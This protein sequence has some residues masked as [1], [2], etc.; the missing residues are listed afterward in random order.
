[1]SHVL[2]VPEMPGPDVRRS[3][4]RRCQVIAGT[5]VDRSFAVILL[6]KRAESIDPIVRRVPGNE[7]NVPTQSNT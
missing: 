6:V 4:H 5:L 1:M 7:M 3:Q 2:I